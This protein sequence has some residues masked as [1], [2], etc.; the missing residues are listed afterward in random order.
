MALTG[1]FNLNDIMKSKSNKEIEVNTK[2]Y[3]SVRLSPYDVVPSQSNFY[4]QE[5]IEELADTFLI[6]GQQQPTVLGRVNGKFKILSGHR[7]NLANIFN[8][9]R[10]YKQYEAVEYLYKDMT[11]SFFELSLIIGN[12]FTRKLTPYEE[13]EQVARLK[14]ALVR[15]RDEDGLEISG[16]LRNVISDLLDTS[17][18]QVAR[19]EAINNNLTEEAKEEFKKGNL[20]MTSAYETSRLPEDEQRKIADKASKG[21]EVKPKDIATMMTEKKKENNLKK[22]SETDTE[23]NEEIA[24]INLVTG[25]IVEQVVPSYLNGKMIDFIKQLNIDEYA[26][27]FCDRC[28][29]V[30][31]GNGCAGLCDLALEC[32]GINKYEV[33][34]RWL[35]QQI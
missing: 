23:T 12:A 18:T 7:R 20:G 1:K 15:A 10:G 24:T 11:E 3:K 4:S 13:T 19:M 14:K 32:K 25:E 17:S 29:G 27:F 5:N 30:G 6:A 28:T 34:K 2:E 16:K 8:I 35:N 26:R 21:E 9:E 33:C 22:V 31:G